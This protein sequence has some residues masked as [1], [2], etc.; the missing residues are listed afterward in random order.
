MVTSVF[1]ILQYFSNTNANNI[2][3]Y[4]THF[5]SNSA[6]VSCLL[7]SY[8]SSRTE[9]AELQEYKKYEILSIA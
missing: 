9:L 5:E 8:S 3:I 2:L 7:H 4:L 6:K 1:Y